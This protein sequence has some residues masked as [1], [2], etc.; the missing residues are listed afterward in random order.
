MRRLVAYLLQW[1]LVSAAVLATSS[2]ASSSST[3]DDTYYPAGV[4]NPLVQQD[5]Y[6]KDASNVLQDLES[7]ESLY[8]AYP[9]C[10]Y[11]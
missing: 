6:Y 10:V 3:R 5:L 4:S 2:A 11:V 1:L 9:S 7:F 8:I